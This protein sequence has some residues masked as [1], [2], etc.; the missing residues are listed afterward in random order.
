MV[1]GS[2]NRPPL[3]NIETHYPLAPFAKD[4]FGLGLF[5][6]DR[7]FP[8]TTSLPILLH[9]TPGSSS[10]LRFETGGWRSREIV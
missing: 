2:V 1:I 5:L 4:H 6:F 7:I 3:G 8:F 9:P 10:S